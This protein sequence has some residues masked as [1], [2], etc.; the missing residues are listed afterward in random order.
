VAR[1]AVAGAIG[2]LERVL[3]ALDGADESQG[4]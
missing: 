1:A 4:G 3:A 2:T